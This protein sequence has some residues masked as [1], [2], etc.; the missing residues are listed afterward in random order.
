[1]NRRL[2]EFI[3]RLNHPSGTPSSAALLLSLD[4]VHEDIVNWI[5]H[6]NQKHGGHGGTKALA[7]LCCVSYGSM[8][9]ELNRTTNPN[10]SPK[11]REGFVKYRA[12]ISLR[13]DTPAT[14]NWNSPSNLTS[15]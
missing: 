12:K 5:S 8:L 10:G 15:K 13:A 4:G 6:Y 7:N 14:R 1:M 2:D 11:A 9:N 3:A